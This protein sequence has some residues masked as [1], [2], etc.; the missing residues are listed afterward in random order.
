MNHTYFFMGGLARSG[1][2]LLTAIL[3]QNP[4]I[5]VSEQSPVCDLTYKLNVLF[6]ENTFYKA[7][8]NVDVRTNV[9]RSLIDNY[10]YNRPEPIIIDKF[11]SWGTQ[12]NLSM[13]QALYTEDAKI[14][15]PVR[16]II[17]IFA[18][19]LVLIKKNKTK[20]YIDRMLEERDIDLSDE[21][22][23]EFIFDGTDGGLKH[24]FLALEQCMNKEKRECFHLI[25]YNDLVDN[26]QEVLYDL[27]DFLN[28]GR[29]QHNYDSIKYEVKSRDA[30]YYGMPGLHD[31]RESISKTS[32]NPEDI[33]PPSIIKKY[34]DIEFWRDD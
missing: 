10:Y 27:Y 16:D 26:P 24:Q 8:P 19:N 2:T 17:E 7:C 4:N 18:S 3:H 6:E 1:S 23:C 11:R 28:I 30:V 32:V 31:V 15:C 29:Y 20:S 33:V 13:I 25:E 12:Y 14:I 5:Y 34:R 21:N 22:R 9:V